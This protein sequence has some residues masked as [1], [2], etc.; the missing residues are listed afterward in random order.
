M[1]TTAGVTFS[2]IGASDGIVAPPTTWAGRAALARGRAESAALWAIAAPGLAAT[3]ASPGTAVSIRVVTPPP[4][5]ASNRQKK[6]VSLRMRKV[7]RS[8][9]ARGRVRNSY[10]AGASPGQDASLSGPRCAR[11]PGRRAAG[12][13]PKPRLNE[14]LNLAPR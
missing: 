2:S 8:V 3:G 9:V 1:L 4:M 11:R 13:Y 7:S 5:A 12:D 14:V 6:V 10:G